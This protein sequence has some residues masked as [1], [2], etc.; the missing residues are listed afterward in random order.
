MKNLM[1]ILPKNSGRDVGGH[2]AVRHQGGRHKRFYRII[3]WKRNKI[4]IPAR[5]DAVEYDPNRTVAIAQVTYTD[6]EKRYILTPIGLAV[7]MRIQS[8]KDAPVKVGNALP[9]GFMP[10]GTVVHNVE[11]KPGKGA[12]MVRS[13]GAQAVILS[14]EGDVV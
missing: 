4:G 2:V 7:G 10:V 3:D 13:A 1:E 12:Q 9:L 8:G 6:G 11:I 14:K 5:V